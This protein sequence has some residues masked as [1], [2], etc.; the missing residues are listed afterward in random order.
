MVQAHGHGRPPAERVSGFRVRHASNPPSSGD[1]EPCAGEEHREG[2]GTSPR[3]AGGQT[4]TSSTY[5]A[6]VESKAAAQDSF[7]RVRGGPLQNQCDSSMD[8]EIHLNCCNKL[9]A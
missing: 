8:V 9:H 2:L 7:Q 6:D 4:S 1:S 3:N 5:E